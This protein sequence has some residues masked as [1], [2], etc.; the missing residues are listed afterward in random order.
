MG[1]LIE[2]ALGSSTIVVIFFFFYHKPLEAPAE[3]NLNFKP[4]KKENRG[5]EICSL[6]LISAWR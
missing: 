1:K 3:L 2:M 4:E 5:V 6:L